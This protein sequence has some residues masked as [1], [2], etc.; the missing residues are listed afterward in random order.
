MANLRIDI[1]LVRDNIRKLD[2]LLRPAGISWTLVTKLLGGNRTVLSAILESP[3]MKLVDSVGD[4]RIENLAAVRQIAPDVRTMYLKP[5]PI[6]RADEVVEHADISLNT[7]LE[8]IKALDAAASAKSVTHDVIVMIEM[9]ELREGVVRGGILDFYSELFEL[10]NIR[11]VGIGT[12]LGCMYGVEPTFDKLIQLSLYRALIE[13]KFD[14]S[15]PIV[16]G[17]S[18]ITLPLLPEGKIPAGVNHLRIGESLFFGRDLRTGGAFAD[19]STDVF[20][21][22]AEI[23]EYARKE[24]V[25]DGTIGTASIGTTPEIAREGDGEEREGRAIAD[26]GEIDVSPQHLTPVDDGVDFAGSTSDMTVYGVDDDKIVVEVGDEIAFE[27]NYSAVA[28]LMHSKYVRKE[29]S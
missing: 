24:R 13:A 1:G 16:S 14:V 12:N 2:T 11:V 29:V 25:P 5:S 27:P 9:G 4:S 23:V 19:L 20:S 8:A 17:G 21:F 15:L 18:S 10:Q 26:F 6:A 3:E 7:S 28:R 22:S